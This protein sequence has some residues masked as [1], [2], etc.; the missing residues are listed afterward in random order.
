LLTRQKSSL[1]FAF[2]TSA[3]FAMDYFEKGGLKHFHP[4]KWVWVETQ[5]TE[6]NLKCLGSL[7]E[8]Q[9]WIEEGHFSSI[10]EESC[11]FG[12]LVVTLKLDHNR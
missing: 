7:D 5:K 2:G 11:F 8:T 12:D 3:K 10:R 4:L 6:E 1:Y 9:N